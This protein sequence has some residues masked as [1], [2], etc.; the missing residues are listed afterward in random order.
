MRPLWAQRRLTCPEVARLL[1]RYLDGEIDDVMAQRIARHLDH[2]RR[3]GLEAE[4]YSA[5]KRSLRA[6]RADVPPEALERLQ[7]FARQLAAD[8][9]GDGVRQLPDE[10]APS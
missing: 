5:I 3:C 9:E 6:H 1:Q 8:K 7:S 4:T 2:C 10:A